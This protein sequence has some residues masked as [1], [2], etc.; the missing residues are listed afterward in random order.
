MQ[1]GMIMVVVAGRKQERNVQRVPQ[2]VPHG[3]LGKPQMQHQAA[4][5]MR[6]L[7]SQIVLLHFA[8]EHC[9]APKMLA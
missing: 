7:P 4:A 8:Q 6:L 9:S 1:H 5:T 2:C 3:N